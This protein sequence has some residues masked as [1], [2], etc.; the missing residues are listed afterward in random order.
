LRTDEPTMLAWA[1]SMTW[2]GQHPTVEL[3]S[4]AYS[5]GVSLSKKEMEPIEQRLLRN[6]DLPKWDILIQPV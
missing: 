1:K 4:S 3:N 2:K 5:K 6:P